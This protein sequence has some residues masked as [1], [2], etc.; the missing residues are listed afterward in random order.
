MGKLLGE[1][2]KSLFVR[3]DIQFS[4]E[5]RIFYYFYLVIISPMFQTS[6]KGQALVLYQT[7][8]KGSWCDMIEI[9][10]LRIEYYIIRIWV[11]I[12]KC[13]IFNTDNHIISFCKTLKSK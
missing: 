8:I 3:K 10:K 9:L 4:I 13:N 2:K 11:L 12:I 5:V 6:F 7:L 1:E